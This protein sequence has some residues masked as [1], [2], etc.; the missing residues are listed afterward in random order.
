MRLKIIDVGWQGSTPRLFQLARLFLEPIQERGHIV[1]FQDHLKIFTTQFP[2]HLHT[3]YSLYQICEV[4]FVEFPVSL[5]TVPIS[6][7]HCE[8]KV[9]LKLQEAIC[10]IY[11]VL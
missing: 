2:Q 9:N 5:N 8:K 7:A 6:P 10:L 11:E 4:I 1:S 3:V